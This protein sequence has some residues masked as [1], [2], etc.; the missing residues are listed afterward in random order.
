MNDRFS[1]AIRAT[2][3]GGSSC[4]KKLLRVTWG[5]WVDFSGGQSNKGN[6]GGWVGGWANVTRV[7]LQALGL[8]TAGRVHGTPITQRDTS[9]VSDYATGCLPCT[10]GRAMHVSNSFGTVL[11]LGRGQPRRHHGQNRSTVTR[12]NS[13]HF[14][15]ASDNCS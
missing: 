15:L 4:D 2:L 14:K 9:R 13:P 6:T 7:T 10:H 5:G 3:L 12:R 1:V 11:V 8:W